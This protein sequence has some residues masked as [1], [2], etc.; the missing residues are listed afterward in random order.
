MKKGV[1]VFVLLFVSLL[2]I[3]F[4]SAEVTS[5]SVTTSSSC[6]GTIVMRLSATTNAHAQIPSLAS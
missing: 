6:S 2:S 3:N 5:C 4:V 1:F